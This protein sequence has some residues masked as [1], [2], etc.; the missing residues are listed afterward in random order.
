MKRISLALS[1]GLVA[2]LVGLSAQTTPA[3]KTDRAKN[4]R[5]V[6]VTGC[7]AEGTEAGSYTLTNAKVSGNPAASPTTTGTAGTERAEKSSSMEHSGSYQ[8]KGGDLKAH[9][10]HKV[11]VTGTT[12]DDKR[13][14]KSANAGTTAT[15]KD[16]PSTLTVKSV[17]MV[18]TTCP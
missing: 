3:D 14:D 9:V 10:G 5:A 12:S 11:E 15:T 16:M 13:T 7:V 8:L 6:T 1:L 2:G 4:D 18:S 17:K